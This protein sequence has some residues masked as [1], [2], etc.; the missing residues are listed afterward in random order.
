MDHIESQNDGKYDLTHLKAQLNRPRRVIYNR[1]E[2]ILQKPYPK[3]GQRFTTDEDVAIFQ[4]ALGR[5]LPGDADE[6][7]ERIGDEYQSWKD[8]EPALQRR[9]IDI[10]IRWAHFI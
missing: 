8:L 5:N 3:R 6:L 4:H 2:D 1:I 9:S 7:K 10:K